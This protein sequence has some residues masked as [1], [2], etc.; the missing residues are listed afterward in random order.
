MPDDS[1]AN[2]TSLSPAAIEAIA[3]GFPPRWENSPHE[4]DAR[5]YSG[6]DAAIVVGEDSVRYGPI[7][8]QA[9]A[10]AIL[11]FVVMTLVLGVIIWLAD[12]RR[13]QLWFV[14]VAAFCGA[15]AVATIAKVV[16][17]FERGGDYLT[18]SGQ[19]IDLPRNGSTLA[20][21]TVLALQLLTGPRRREHGFGMADE[22]SH[23]SLLT[24]EPSEEG[25]RIVRHFVNAGQT[26]ALGRGLQTDAAELAEHLG[27]P[28]FEVA[29]PSGYDLTS[30]ID[31]PP[32]ESQ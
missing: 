9:R 23:L 2:G 13:S 6:I 16:G 26:T 19:Q 3:A 11:G 31:T 21:D 27:C 29:C 14:P 30:D 4:T 7:G 25:R 17:Q 15:T 12:G 20:L 24:V 8:G 22:G 5:M 18:R 32:T 28:L 10:A 1:A